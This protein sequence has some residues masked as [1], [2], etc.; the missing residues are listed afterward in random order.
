ME[1]ELKITCTCH[2]AK[3][4]RCCQTS[5]VAPI[6]QKNCTGGLFNI[7][8]PNLPSDL[9]AA[10]SG[11]TSCILNIENLLGQAVA[12]FLLNLVRVNTYDG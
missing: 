5:M 7:L 10:H 4:E 8:N 6:A 9:L 12:V 3:I 11:N 1:P 2:Q